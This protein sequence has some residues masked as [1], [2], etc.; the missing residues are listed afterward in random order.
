MPSVSK[1]TLR[2]MK[3]AKKSRS[4]SKRNKN[5]VKRTMKQTPRN[6]YYTHTSSY[7]KKIVNGKVSE[8]AM[9]VLNSSNSNS[10]LVRKMENGKVKEAEIPK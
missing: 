1:R 6:Y 3:K 9:E 2:K 10:I 4:K 8:K 7:S 5:A